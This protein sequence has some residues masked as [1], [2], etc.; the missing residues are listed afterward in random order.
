MTKESDCLQRLNAV[1]K[2][3]EY[4]QKWNYNSVT[5]L[6]LS[7]LIDI[8]DGKVPDYVI[9]TYEEYLKDNPITKGNER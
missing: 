5:T 8:R 4:Q 3:L 1:I 7:Y 9:K 2:S 6:I